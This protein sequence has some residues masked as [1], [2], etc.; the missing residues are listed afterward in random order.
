MKASEALEAAL[1]GDYDKLMVKF[2][3]SVLRQK[4]VQARMPMID[5]R[6][7]DSPL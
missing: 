4:P 7:S 1:S 2:A 5:V 6:F 3:M